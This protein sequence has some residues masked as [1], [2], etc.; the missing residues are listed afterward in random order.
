MGTLVRKQFDPLS[1]STDKPININFFMLNYICFG[2]LTPPF[3]SSAPADICVSL[4]FSVRYYISCPISKSM[5]Q[6]VECMRQ[7]LF[8]AHMIAEL[9]Q[10]ILM[11]IWRIVSV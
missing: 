3:L 7:L 9:W 6:Q 5:N 4:F 11:A 10:L 8:T 2:F 1:N